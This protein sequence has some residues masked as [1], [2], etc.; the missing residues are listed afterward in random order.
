L[1]K[2]KLMATKDTEKVDEEEQM[3]FQNV[4]TAIQQYAPYTVCPCALTHAAVVLNG[5]GQLAGNNRRRKD[6]FALPREDQALIEQLGYKRKLSQVDD[7]ILANAAFLNQIVANPEIFENGGPSESEEGGDGDGDDDIG[8][9]PAA[10]PGDGEGSSTPPSRGHP[11]PHPRGHSHKHTHSHTHGPHSNSN[12][13]AAQENTR[14]RHR[15]REFDMDKVRSTLK[16][17]VRDWSEEVRVDT[18]SLL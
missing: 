5:C 6:I 7:A 17:L 4:I 12:P 11:H 18:S 10:S 13:S 15:P 2:L 8:E 1:F 14:R 16:Q 9:T 3:H